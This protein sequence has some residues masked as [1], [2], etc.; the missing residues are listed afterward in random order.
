MSSVTTPALPSN[1]KHT[2]NNMKH[3]ELIKINEECAVSPRIYRILQRAA[4]TAWSNDLEWVISDNWNGLLD[5][6]REE[7]HI[8]TRAKNAGLTRIQYEEQTLAEA[9]ER[10]HKINQTLTTGTE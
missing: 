7:L 4:R 1:P 9:M 2:R 10:W 5:L 3:T 8:Y 6:F